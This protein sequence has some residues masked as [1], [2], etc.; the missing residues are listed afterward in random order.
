M[1]EAWH[2]R[3]GSNSRFDKTRR[4][5]R[6]NFPIRLRFF[7]FVVH[8]RRSWCIPP[9]G[10]H[11]NSRKCTTTAGRGSAGAA[12][13]MCGHSRCD[14][15]IR[16]RFFHFVV[17]SRRS[18]CIPPAGTHHNSRKCTT[19]AGLLGWVHWGATS[20]WLRAASWA[21]CGVAWCG[22]VWRASRCGVLVGV[23]CYSGLARYLARAN[24]INDLL[25]WQ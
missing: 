6:C 14:F 5:S 21:W 22:V 18:W 7:H 13:V 23:A 2:D 20:A 4:R 1:R 9:A 25:H 17:H 8:S 24:P 16:L 3:V 15:P 10:T 12:V 19:T 11:H